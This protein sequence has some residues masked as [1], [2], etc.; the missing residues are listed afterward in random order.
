M[1]KKVEDKT[2]QEI[3][4]PNSDKEFRELIK[5]IT[6]D[7]LRKLKKEAEIIKY[8]YTRYIERTKNET[9]PDLL[10][11]LKSRGYRNKSYT[12][13][14]GNKIL[15]KEFSLKQFHKLLSNPIYI[16]KVRHKD[17][18]YDGEHKPIISEDEWQ[19]V[20]GRMQKLS[21]KRF[22]EEKSERPKLFGKIYDYHG[23]IMTSS[24]SYKYTSTGRYKMRY[25]INQEIYKMGKSSSEFQ[26]IRAENIDNVVENNLKQFFENIT[27]KLNSS[28]NQNLISQLPDL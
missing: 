17:K 21:Y 3:N 1:R 26:R 13:Q 4:I 16:G 27:E 12:S 2:L 22:A 23:N 8:I 25:Y 14:K 9:L 7:E 11:D 10:D 5:K 6:K 18:I 24:Y 19:K 28:N 15:G 20:Q